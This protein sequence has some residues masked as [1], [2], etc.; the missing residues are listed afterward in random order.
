MTQALL[1][2]LDDVPVLSQETADEW[3]DRRR[4]R[5]QPAARV[6]R[7]G[8]LGLG[9]VQRRDAGEA[10]HGAPAGP[11]ML[12][13]DAGKLKG[14]LRLRPAADD[15]V[16]ERVPRRRMAFHRE[17]EMRRHEELRLLVDRRPRAPPPRGVH[18][19]AVR[20]VHQA[21]HGVIE[22]AGEIHDLANRGNLRVAYVGEE[23]GRR[24]RILGPRRGHEDPDAA[25][26]LVHGVGVHPDVCRVDPLFAG[27]RWDQRARAGAVE[28]PAVIAALDLL[29]I[30]FAVGEWHRAVRADIAQRERPSVIAAS[31][32]D[33]FAQQRL[34]DHSSWLQRRGRER[35]VP[36]IAQQ[37]RV[38]HSLLGPAAAAGHCSR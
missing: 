32:N 18:E 4:E 7:M 23:R 29:A 20:R 17:A 33:G 31:E 25:L 19:W 36:K 2:L 22:K 1:L 13:P 11:D 28:T 35:I 12:D 16:A 30:E 3:S 34:R 10:D 26:Q 27:Q 6:D 24:R 38:L 8:D 5:L 37:D 14:D 15:L 9:V 21:D